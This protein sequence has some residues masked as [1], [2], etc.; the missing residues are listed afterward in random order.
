MFWEEKI[1]QVK[2]KFSQDE[3]R[4]PFSD[5]SGIM[6]K[7]EARFVISSKP[8]YQYTNW[9]EGL[10]E[11]VVL[12]KI[13]HQAIPTVIS[14]LDPATNYWVVIVLGDA[15]MAQQFV[16]DC[17]PAAIEH[18]AA[19]APG[20][21]YIGDKKYQWLV[22]FKMDQ[23]ENAVTLIKAVNFLTPFDLQP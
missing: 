22:H 2:K 17:K 10:K 5:W 19:I 21:F 6:K 1:D 16:Y 13:A 23:T 18:L 8:D 9:S 7:M 3:F 11:K 20:D 4:V 15:S 12:R 14:T